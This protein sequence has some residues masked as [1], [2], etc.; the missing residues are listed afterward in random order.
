M[1]WCAGK[2]RSGKSV[3]D[4]LAGSNPSTLFVD[5]LPCASSPPATNTRPLATVV[6]TSWRSIDALGSAFHGD[7]E[8]GSELVGPEDPGVRVNGS[9]SVVAL[10][11]V[12]E[13]AAAPSTANTEVPTAAKPMPWR[14][15]FIG[16]SVDQVLPLMSYETA[17]PNPLVAPSPPAATSRPPTTAAP[18][19]P[20][21]AGM[22]GSF[23]HDPPLGSRR[24][25]ARTFLLAESSRPPT[26]YTKFPADAP[27]RWSRG[28]ERF[29][30]SLQALPSQISVS[31][32]SLPSR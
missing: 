23:S 12:C 4:E 11:C 14:G 30:P 31:A 1:A 22:S 3:H 13:G 15:V 9:S 8:A 19:S 28:V 29:G 7:A 26:P 27:A 5:P 16:G 2:G 24:S 32:R 17:S 21:G 25:S 10:A 20:R 18:R 6:A